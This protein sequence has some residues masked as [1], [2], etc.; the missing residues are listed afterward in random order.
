MPRLTDPAELRARVAA[1]RSARLATLR[2]D[3]S[4]RLVPI[5][6]AVVDGALC[7]AVDSVKP[8]TSAR[9]ARLAD[10]RRDPRVGVL[11]DRYDEDWAL[12]WWVRVDATAVVVDEHPSAAAALRAK[13]EP[14]RDAD[15]AGPVLVLTPVRWTGWSAT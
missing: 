15:L 9:L 4:P 6:F 5:T 7:S 2:A 10:V 1:A 14:Y 13:Y 11:I 12:L 8:K 3:G